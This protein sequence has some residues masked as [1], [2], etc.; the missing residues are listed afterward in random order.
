MHPAMNHEEK[1]NLGKS[2]GLMGLCGLLLFLLTDPFQKAGAAPDCNAPLQCGADRTEAYFPM[3]EGKRFA[4]VVNQTSVIAAPGSDG[5]SPYVHLVDSLCS[6]GLKPEF[7]FTPE[8]GLRGT[9]DAGQAVSD[10]VDSRTGLSIVSLYGKNRKPTPA[11]MQGLDA[12]VFD[13]QDVGCRFYTYLSTLHYVME[14]C[15]EN[16]V[17]LMVL[18]RPNPN[19]TVDGPV[20]K[21]GFHSF[22]GMHPVPVL[23]GCTLGE[24]ARMISG[25]GWTAPSLRLTVIPVNGWK[26]GQPYPLPV[27][28]SPNL[29]TDRAVRLYPSLCLF[30]GTVISVGR[31]T[32]TP[33]E[34]IGAPDARFGRFTFTPQPTPG[35]STPLYEGQC[36]YGCP[37][38]DT[39]PACRFSLEFLYEMYRRSGMGE[40]FFNRAR[41]F[42]LLAGSDALRCLML[43][44]Y[45]PEV[46]RRSWQEDLSAYRRM[47]EKYLIY[48]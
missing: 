48:E 3:L 4:V 28:P 46:I 17:E 24:M 5:A 2:L 10:D 31:G 7:I 36:C 27:A 29:P 6:A 20:L 44:G 15:E 43:S 32:A 39:V 45:T 26:H 12:V 11:Q 19:D 16:G 42:D 33:F 23:H 37:L 18:D 1:S 30:E 25:E 47:R 40:K 35:A 21:E 9:A 38:S 8:H 34:V 13:L 22:V 14:A 41:F